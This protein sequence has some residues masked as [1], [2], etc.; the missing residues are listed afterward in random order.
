[1]HGEAAGHRR[2]DRCGCSGA[3]EVAC[4]APVALRSLTCCCC[5]CV[6]KSSPVVLHLNLASDF[7]VAEGCRVLLDVERTQQ[8]V[9]G[10]S[11]Q[12]ERA[13][14]AFDEIGLL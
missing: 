3:A 13:G 1:M 9:R 11:E 4:T 12:L 2:A 6:L 14:A 5:A 10:A 8:S 7:D